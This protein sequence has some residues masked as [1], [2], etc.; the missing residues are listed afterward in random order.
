MSIPKKDI[1]PEIDPAEDDEEASLPQADETGLTIEPAGED[2]GSLAAGR[3]AILR[4]A[5]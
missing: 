4:Y 3:A 1:E 2:E 5:T